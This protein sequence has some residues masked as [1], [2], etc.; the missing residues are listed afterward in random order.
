MIETTTILHKRGSKS[1]DLLFVNNFIL[2]TKG[3]DPKSC[4]QSAS[5]S[6][7]SILLVLMIL[8]Q[9]K[10]KVSCNHCQHSL[11]KAERE[12]EKGT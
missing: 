3:C 1:M 4:C 11:C 2:S 6:L 5:P 9:P 12:K 8:L 10:T 7:D